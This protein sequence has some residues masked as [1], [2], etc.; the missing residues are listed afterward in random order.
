[1][2][3]RRIVFVA[4][5]LIV[6]ACSALVCAQEP[7]RRTQ[8]E[9]G[10]PEQENG[11]RGVFLGQ[12]SEPAQLHRVI[13][14]L[15]IVLKTD[16]GSKLVRPD[17]S[18]RSGDHFRFEITANQDG[19]LYVMHAVPTRDWQQLWP[20]KSDI[21]KIRAQQSYEIPPRPGIFIFDKDVGNEFFYVVVR[22]DATPPALGSST[23]QTRRTEDLAKTQTLA[24]KTPAG[25]TINF[26]VRDPFGETTRGVIF[27]PGKNDADPYLYFSA[28][29]QDSVKSAKI[30][31][32]LHHID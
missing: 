26:L 9:A 2:H 16:E 31:F 29:P 15:A 18:F 23:A 12:D 4:F 14:R 7:E 21:N 20:S 1:M 13:G 8:E 6:G 10:P 32:Q 30:K 28:T 24:P 3:L 22:P 5:I 25:K 11:L 19:W 27:D 17:Y